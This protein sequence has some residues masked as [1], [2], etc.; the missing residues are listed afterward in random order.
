MSNNIISMD[1]HL[2]FTAQAEDFRCFNQE[3]HAMLNALKHIGYSSASISGVM[4]IVTTKSKQCVFAEVADHLLKDKNTT[5]DCLGKIA[6]LFSNV[7]SREVVNYGSTN[8]TGILI[9][10]IDYVPLQA[11]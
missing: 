4:G 7:E 2:N 1:G 6:R 11:F 10:N 5:I 3:V 8:F 9:W